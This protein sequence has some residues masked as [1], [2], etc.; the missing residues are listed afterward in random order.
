MVR[1]AMKIARDKVKYETKSMKLFCKY[2]L[3]EGFEYHGGRDIMN[4]Y[5]TGEEYITVT[6]PNDEVHR[7]YLAS[8]KNEYKSLKDSLELELAIRYKHKDDDM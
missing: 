8:N 6:D 3:L 4:G 2:G 7:Y 1:W 5:F